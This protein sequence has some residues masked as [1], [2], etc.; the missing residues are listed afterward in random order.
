MGPIKRATIAVG[1]LALVSG[2]AAASAGTLYTTIPNLN[3]V[4]NLADAMPDTTA[5]NSNTDACGS[6]SV[7]DSFT[8]TGTETISGFS[9]YAYFHLAEASDFLGTNWSV[10]GSTNSGGVLE[11]D[12]GKEID[13]GAALGGAVSL[14]SGP[15]LV[16]V[17]LAKPLVLTAGAYYFGFQTNLSN[18]SDYST[19][20]TSYTYYPKVP[21]E[22]S[23]IPWT[24]YFSQG[25]GAPD[26]TIPTFYQAAFS[27]GSAVP[28]PSVWVMT[29]IGFAGLGWIARRRVSRLQKA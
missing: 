18:S 29:L 21:P 3:G 17:T 12:I 5:C 20:A 13:S 7:Y 19:Y 28:E 11:P 16:T 22:V 9:Y 2:W 25:G 8:L 24:S 1:A 6:W 27:V 14:S 26:L 15:Q 23:P 10:W 4:S